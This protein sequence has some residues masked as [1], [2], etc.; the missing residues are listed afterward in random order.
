MSGIQT[1]GQ[2]IIANIKPRVGD[3]RYSVE[4]LEEKDSNW[5]LANGKPVAQADYPKLYE[6][7]GGL[8]TNWV[9]TPTLLK[10]D[11]KLSNGKS[12]A[13]EFIASA[14]P[15]EKRFAIINTGLST[16]SN[17]SLPKEIGLLNGVE[18]VFN[19]VPADI[20]ETTTFFGLFNVRCS[21][22]QAIAADTRRDSLS[23]DGWYYEHRATTSNSTARIG[24]SVMAS[25]PPSDIIFN[26]SHF[27][28]FV[29]AMPTQSR[30]VYG[31]VLTMAKSSGT[32]D[33]WG[34][35]TG[36][37]YCKL[38]WHCNFKTVILFALMTSE[39]E[40][41]TKFYYSDGDVVFKQI[42]LSYIYNDIG[43]KLNEGRIWIFKHNGFYYL[44]HSTNGNI[45]KT[46]DFVT[47]VV[48]GYSGIQITYPISIEKGLLL[49]N[50]NTP[51][52]RGYSK[53]YAYNIDK[54]LLLTKVT[55]T[56]NAVNATDNG[57]LYFSKTTTI[58]YGVNIYRLNVLDTNVIFNLPVINP[59]GK[60]K[61]YIRGKE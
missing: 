21:N 25:T 56:L 18:T 17:T 31:R 39:V 14:S 51:Q 34:G 44:Q 6:L 46:T 26:G 43:R 53:V 4:N 19:V 48:H 2:A 50:Y 29:Y 35:F 47:F 45:Y 37:K 24:I 41:S 58:P 61:A 22:E 36:S 32:F 5:L 15:D 7:L 28:Y 40:S 27:V 49:F 23:S 57:V 60:A 54:N 1:T 59:E 12:F 3:I 13:S 30:N 16:D 11:I 8:E 38:L 55:E 52:G 10:S 9:G 20:V 42:D 33:S